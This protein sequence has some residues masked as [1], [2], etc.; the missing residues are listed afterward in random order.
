MS[1]L[2][3]KAV[4]SS[5]ASI[6]DVSFDELL[7]DTIGF[8]FKS[9][10]SIWILFKNPL[11][12]FTAAKAP[13][14]QNR[15]SPSFR[16]Y[17]GLIALSAGMKFIYRDEK[18]PMVQV[19]KQ[20]FERIKADVANRPDPS[21]KLN[22]ENMD[23]TAMAVTT[24]KWY[25]LISP[26]I[27]MFT[28]CMLGLIYWGFGEKLNP[29]VRIRYV[30]ATMVPA[31]FVSFV[32][33]LPIYFMVPQFIGVSSFLGLGLMFGVLWITAYRGAFPAVATTSG[34]VGRATALSALIFF[35][36]IASAVVAVIIGIAFA[37]KEA[38]STGVTL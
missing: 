30:F 13:F 32:S 5:Q 8:S 19:Y 2:S 9:V 18:S 21:D 16:I 36:M 22:A 24:L 10:R 23:T 38:I 6:R 12:Y 33:I 28:F 7:D 26:L 25:I 3:N 11:E 35:F 1:R 27:T 4:D 29:V 14:W 37:M 15:F 20:Q 17:A 31:S 34:R